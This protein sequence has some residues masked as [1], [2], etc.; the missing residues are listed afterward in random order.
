MTELEQARRTIEE[1]D[2]QMAELFCRRMQAAEAVAHYKAENRLPIFDPARET[3]LLKKNSA[4]VQDLRY[5]PYY[6]AFLKGLMDLS[7]AYQATRIGGGPVG[8]FGAE[9]SHTHVAEQHLFPVA[10]DEYVNRLDAVDGD[11]VIQFDNHM[12]LLPGDL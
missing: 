11:D 3:A 9:G 7:K 2:A 4:Y 10:L 1:V 12:D 8:Y 5:L 6:E